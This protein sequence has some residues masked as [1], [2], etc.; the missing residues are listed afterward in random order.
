[1]QAESDRNVSNQRRIEPTSSGDQSIHKYNQEMVDWESRPFF[2]VPLSSVW[3]VSLISNDQLIVKEAW[4]VG[5]DKG[6]ESRLPRAIDRQTKQRFRLGDEKSQITPI[7]QPFPLYSLPLSLSLYFSSVDMAVSMVDEWRFQQI[8][9][10][11]CVW[12]AISSERH[13]WSKLLSPRLSSS[14]EFVCSPEPVRKYSQ[15]A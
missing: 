10:F 6:S 12:F 9:T 4:N 15:T 2:F 1:M 5:T 3:C 7:S 8:L 11:H 14:S 13:Q